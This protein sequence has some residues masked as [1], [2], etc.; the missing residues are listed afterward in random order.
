M[1]YKEPGKEPLT[2]YERGYEA[3]VNDFELPADAPGRMSKDFMN[4]YLDGL[5]DC[6]LEEMEAVFDAYSVDDFDTDYTEYSVL[7]PCVHG[8]DLDREFCPQGCRV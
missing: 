5:G 8:V 6:Q 7:G 4:G 2:V 3:G 1:S